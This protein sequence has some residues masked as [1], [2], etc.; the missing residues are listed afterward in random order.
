MILILPVLLNLGPL[1]ETEMDFWWL[2]WQE[3]VSI[4][5][6]L[7]SEVNEFKCQQYWPD[8]GKKQYGPFHVIIADQ[9]VFADYTV[10]I[11]SVSVN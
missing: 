6:M 2:I 1:L 3:R 5:V 9:Q 4:I 8:S 10:R 7:T 11:L